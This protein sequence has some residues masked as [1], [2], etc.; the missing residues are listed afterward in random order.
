MGTGYRERQQNDMKA[1]MAKQNAELRQHFANDGIDIQTTWQK[2]KQMKLQKRPE[3]DVKKQE[4]DKLQS[5]IQQGKSARENYDVNVAV[6]LSK[7]DQPSAGHV[8]D[9]VDVVA[10]DMPNKHFSRNVER[11]VVEEN[12]TVDESI[13]SQ[14]DDFNKRRADSANKQQTMQARVREFLSRDDWMYFS[15]FIIIHSYDDYTKKVRDKI[16]ASEITGVYLIANVSKFKLYVGYRSKTI[17]K[18]GQHF[19]RRI[20]SSDSVPAIREDLILEDTMCVN[21][22]KLADTDFDTVKELA[23]Y[24]IRKYDCMEPRGYNKPIVRKY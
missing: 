14:I 2:Q 3:V 17:E 10:D 5:L 1:L 15:K 13:Q 21:F 4:K 11:R 7:K 8:F 16:S 23:D 6:D 19:R 20:G 22:V 12:Q 24:Y 9:V 18:C